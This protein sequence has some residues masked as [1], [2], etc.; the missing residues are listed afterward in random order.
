M[1]VLV[2]GAGP[3]GLT[4]GLELARRGVDSVVIEQREAPS[5]LSRAVGITPRSLNLLEPSG[6][7]PRLLAEGVQ[8]AGARI[9]R[10][11]RLLLDLPFRPRRTRFG[12]AFILGLAQDRTEAHLAEAY[13]GFGGELRYGTELTD[14]ELRDSEVIATTRSGVRDTFSYVVAADGVESRCREL[15]G[16]PFDGIELPETWSI[17][18]VRASNWPNAQHFTV[19]LLGGDVAVVAPLEAERFRLVSSTGD[20]LAALP[21]DLDVKEVRRRDHFKISVRV[22]REYKKGRVLL[23][24]DAAHCHSPVGGRGMNLGIADAVEL[25]ERIASHRAEGYGPGR[26]REAQRTIVGSERFRKL[27]VHP[28]PSIGR[29]VNGGLGL[30]ARVGAL[31]RLMAEFVLY[32]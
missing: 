28:N 9:Y 30:V 5:V 1:R 19:C 27:A 6:V 7:S 21:L 4:A 31:Q 15:L 24:G 18:D 10:R 16:I 2:V 32:A 14:L 13:R 29:V 8:F 12:Y 3:T 17:A 11:D 22:A 23:A 20:S 25:A 26:K